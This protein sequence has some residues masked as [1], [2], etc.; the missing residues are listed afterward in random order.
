ARGYRLFPDLPPRTRQCPAP[1][2]GAERRLGRGRASGG[3]LRSAAVRRGLGLGLRLRLA[4]RRGGVRAA[5]LPGAVPSAGAG[6]VGHVPAAPLQLEAR[7]RDQTPD[8]ALA[9][10]AAR[11]RGIGDALHLLEVPAVSAAV[12][13]SRHPGPSNLR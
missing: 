5:V 4:F 9:L 7:A 12:L 3:R 1:V 6:V 13:V 11:E 8:L 10:G 2:G